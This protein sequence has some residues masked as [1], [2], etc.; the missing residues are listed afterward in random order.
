MLIRD[1]AYEGMPK[2]TRAE[3]HEQVAGWL[4]RKAGD[5][6]AEFEE[7]IGYH[8]ERAFAYRVELGSPEPWRPL[9]GE[10]ARHLAAAGRRAL[11]RRDLWAAAGLLERA[12][13]LLPVASR[14]YRQAG[15]DL[16]YA[17]AHA[18]V[19]AD[20][21]AVFEDVEREADAA[22]DRVH[23]AHARIDLAEIRSRVDPE[24]AADQGVAEAEAAMLVFKERGDDLGM[25]KAWC[26]I[27]ERDHTLARF[28]PFGQASER[29][30]SY[31]KRTGDWSLTSRALGSIAH[32]VTMGP[33][34]I[35]EAIARME[36]ILRDSADDRDLRAR[37]R[38]WMGILEAQRGRVSDALGAE[39]EA[40]AIFRDLGVEYSFGVFGLAAGWLERFL[41]R[42]DAAE[43]VLRSSDQI[44]ERA[45][46]RSV[47]STVLSV[48]AQV[49]LEQGRP[50]DAETAALFAIELGSSDDL[51]TVS[52]AQSVL[53]R[54]QAARGAPGGVEVA[55]S[56][57]ELAERTDMLWLQGGPGNT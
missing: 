57:V 30:L 23:V 15:L 4:V 8:L 31:G 45:G 13:S 17:L 44:C 3:L 49:L 16:G 19:F 40:A 52:A 35:P 5:R 22:S 48:L 20:A 11:A 50:D 26:L 54:V 43:Q 56:A 47:R 42:L 33:T 27:G 1:A 18:G 39:A 34:I 29:A 51:V 38:I 9:A 6:L 37:V 36:G 2:A 55:R 25:A 32:A 53:G 46:E 12:R 24:G 21:Q 10:A 41:G 7:I 14:D 28:E